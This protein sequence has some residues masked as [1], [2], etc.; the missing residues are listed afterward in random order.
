MN[1]ESLKDKLNK[2]IKEDKGVVL[3]ENTKTYEEELSDIDIIVDDI[4]SIDQFEKDYSKESNGWHLFFLIKGAI[5]F[6]SFFTIG[7][8]FKGNSSNLNII[9]GLLI[10][11]TSI[12]I[13]LN[14]KSLFNLFRFGNNGFQIMNELHTVE[15]FTAINIY[16][17]NEIINKR[18]NYEN[19]FNSIL[20]FGLITFA[21]SGTLTIL[22]SP[23]V[24]SI[25]T[26]ISH[27]P[28]VL[29][30]I[31]G[32]I[33]TGIIYFL[34]KKSG[35]IPLSVI[36][37]VLTG[38]I[39]EYAVYL[40]DSKNTNIQ[41]VAKISENKKEDLSNAWLSKVYV[42]QRMIKDEN[43]E[44]KLISAYEKYVI[45]YNENNFIST[46]K[47]ENNLIAVGEN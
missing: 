21:F 33:G 47:K 38:G 25:I 1:K 46:D 4:F 7:M 32:F 27:H 16:K 15:L 12:G 39:V 45:T 10:F 20:K 31:L 30:T 36:I 23:F 43:G 14:K 28:G 26:N 42:P 5:L 6:M 11:A 9:Y 24:Y 34:T 41:E 44:N 13:F 18:Q 19:K 17:A 35:I 37:S 3:V 8:L 22:S 2:T 29:L 40:E